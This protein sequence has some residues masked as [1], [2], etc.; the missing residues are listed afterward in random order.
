MGHLLR[1]SCICASVMTGKYNNCSPQLYEARIQKLESQGLHM[2]C[3]RHSLMAA[4]LVFLAAP[5]VDLQNPLVTFVKVLDLKLYLVLVKAASCVKWVQLQV[6]A[7]RLLNSC[8][9]ME[10]VMVSQE[11]YHSW[12]TATATEIINQVSVIMYKRNVKAKSI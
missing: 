6:A 1:S 10:I 4:W 11:S 9:L 7:S 8:P 2:F 12:C 3:H 5:K